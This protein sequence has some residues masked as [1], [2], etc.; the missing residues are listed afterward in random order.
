VS[1][2]RELPGASALQLPFKGV[3]RLT[4]VTPI[5]ALAIRGR[6]N[7]RGDFLV[8]TTPPADPALNLGDE[9]FIPQIVDGAGYSTDIV[10]YDLL[11]G[12]PLSGNIYFFDQSGQPI[13]PGLHQ[14]TVLPSP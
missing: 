5:A 2:I 3:L 11:G 14:A 9:T 6:Y 12:S 4:S 1:F 8:S 10:I 13:D 7:E